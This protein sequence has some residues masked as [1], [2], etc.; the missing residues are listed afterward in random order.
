M[1][2][3]VDQN[4]NESINCVL[5]INQYNVYYKTLEISEIETKNMLILLH[6]MYSETEIN[7]KLS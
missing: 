4:D 6:F 5:T 1:T 7:F 3:V 2:A